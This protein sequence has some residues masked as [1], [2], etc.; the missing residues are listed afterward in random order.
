MKQ[1]TFFMVLKGLSFGEK[2]IDKKWRTHA[3]N[4]VKCTECSRNLEFKNWTDLNFTTQNL[5][6]GKEYCILKKKKLLKQMS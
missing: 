2:K 1:K 5:S 3:L 4:I 6:H